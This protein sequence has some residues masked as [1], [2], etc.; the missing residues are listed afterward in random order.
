MSGRLYYLERILAIIS[1]VFLVQASYYKLIGHEESVYLFTFL[2]VEPYGRI[3]IGSLELLASI[4]LIIPRTALY[5]SIIGVS[6]MVGAIISHV[7]ITDL[8]IPNGP[9]LFILAVIVFLCCF[10]I[11]FMRKEQLYLLFEGAFEND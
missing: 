2:E 6:I 11:L 3:T 7:F 5:G 8:I 1:I 10:F 9:T 4:L